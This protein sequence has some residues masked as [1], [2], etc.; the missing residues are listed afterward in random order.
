MLSSALRPAAER[1]KTG[2]ALHGEQRVTLG[3]QACTTVAALTRKLEQL[4][5]G[6]GFTGNAPGGP[7]RWSTKRSGEWEP[8]KPKLVVEVQY[9]QVT[10][11][12]FRH[13]TRFLRWRPDKALEQC[14]MSQLRQ[15]ARPSRLLAAMLC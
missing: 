1:P 2:T 4:R 13:G 10:G 12:R 14:T 15:E 5:G 8:L 7:S 6:P 11:Q 3:T 9:D